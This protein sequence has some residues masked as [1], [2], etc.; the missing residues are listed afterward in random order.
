MLLAQGVD[1]RIYK[2]MQKVA[3]VTT[4]GHA[5]GNAMSVSI[6]ERIAGRPGVARLLSDLLLSC[7]C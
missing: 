4:I 2:S 3:K 1:D 6:V 7:S 5:V